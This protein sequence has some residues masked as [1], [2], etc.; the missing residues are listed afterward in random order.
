MRVDSLVATAVLASAL[1]GCDVPPDIHVYVYS[2]IQGAAD[3]AVWRVRHNYR[4]R[5]RAVEPLPLAAAHS[6]NR[7]LGPARFRV[8][9]LGDLPAY[10][11]IQIDLE[12]DAPTFPAVHRQRIRVLT[13]FKPKEHLRLDVWFHPFVGVGGIG[14]VGTVRNG[15][16]DAC[17]VPPGCHNATTSETAAMD[18]PPGTSVTPDEIDS[19]ESEWQGDP[20]ATPV[21]PV[22]V[23]VCP[24]LMEDN[25][26]ATPEFVPP[27]V[28]DA[29]VSDASA[30]V[31]TDGPVDMAAFVDSGVPGMDVYVPFTP[32]CNGFDND[33]NGVVDDGPCPAGSTCDH[34][35]CA[36]QCV[37]GACSSGQICSAGLCVD[38]A[39]L[40][41]S[42]SAG[43]LCIAGRCVDLCA[44]VT[45]PAAQMCRAGRCYDACP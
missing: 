20:P 32:V 13:R 29:S 25:G 30:D 8:V 44:G 34:G 14:G 5:T 35:Q 16:G 38:T 45:C 27:A 24:E 1:A 9:P 10:E 39:C 37:E 7:F 12:R 18:G 42:C 26:S 28:P 22:C 3:V 4:L 33:C 36:P 41:V 11:W 2:D 21:A 15:D 19:D 31:R 17:F 6:F 43:Q 23:L 40:G